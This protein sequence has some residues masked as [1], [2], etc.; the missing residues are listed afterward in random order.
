LA[1]RGRLITKTSSNVCQN[2]DYSWLNREI[3]DRY[4]TINLAINREE[5]DVLG[6]F[7]D[8]GVFLNKGVFDVDVIWDK[9]SYYIEHYWAMYEPHIREFRI[10]DND[11]T[12]YSKFE[13][14]YQKMAKES[15]KN[16]LNNTAKTQA[17]I[18]K[19]IRCEAGST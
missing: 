16:K 2:L 7:E 11:D 10:S 17:Q 13:Y 18:A 14:L 1:V 6:F 19:F 12:W 9:Y 3:C 15:K 8:L 5:G 4:N